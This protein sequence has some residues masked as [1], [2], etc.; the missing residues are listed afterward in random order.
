MQINSVFTKKIGKNVIIITLYK[1]CTRILSYCMYFLPIKVKM[2]L[3]NKT[4]L[5]YS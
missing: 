5:M 3:K 1:T 2:Q 4:F